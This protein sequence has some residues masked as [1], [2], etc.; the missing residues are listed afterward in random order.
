MNEL[1]AYLHQFDEAWSHAYESFASAMEGVG[2]EAAFVQPA[3][4]ASE[5][6]E[7]GWPAPGTIAWQLAHLTHCKRHYTQHFERVVS[8]AAELPEATPWT[9]LET[10]A[11]LKA[12]LEEAHTRERAA[13]QALQ[14][15]HLDAL[16]GNGMGFREFIAMVIRH[17]IWHASQIAVARRLIG[18]S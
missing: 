18:A 9:P 17:D 3:A 7:A 4:Y 2:E 15:E 8:G 14:P 5:P 11:E 12:A 6:L 13:L 10:L 16:A 1:S